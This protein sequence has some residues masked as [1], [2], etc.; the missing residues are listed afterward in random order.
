MERRYVIISIINDLLKFVHA[1]L[2]KD[3][4]ALTSHVRKECKDN[5]I[6]LFY[7]S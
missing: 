1:E 3:K 6:E 7:G 5:S 2:E 4:E